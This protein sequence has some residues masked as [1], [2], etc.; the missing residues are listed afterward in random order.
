[1]FGQRGRG[2]ALAA[3]LIAAVVLAPFAVSLID[4]GELVGRPHFE[5]SHDPSR[6]SWHHDH[7][8]C[9]QLLASS[10][11][12]P[13]HRATT[14][15]RIRVLLA[16]TTPTHAAVTPRFSPSTPRAPPALG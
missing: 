3:T 7:A 5:S 14:P 8:A 11:A 6:C 13:G 9:A 4:A 15:L 16:P 12:P 10:W 2:S 1:M